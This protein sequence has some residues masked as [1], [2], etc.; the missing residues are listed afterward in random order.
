MP[1][2]RTK[3]TQLIL[4]KLGSQEMGGQ[5]SGFRGQRKLTVQESISIR[6]TDFYRRRRSRASGTLTRTHFD[7]DQ[8]HVRYV[9]DS[10]GP[11]TISLAYRCGDQDIGMLIRLQSTETR[12]EGNRWWFTCPLSV[13][14]S[15]CGRRVHTL[16]LP[17]GARYFGCRQC[18]RLSYSSSQKAHEFERF[19]LGMDKFLA[20]AGIYAARLA[21]D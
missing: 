13:D 17:P 7:R 21:A 5:G 16:H 1:L 2:D 12:F 18:H 20:R 3:Q 9:V 10:R 11:W 8:F 6:V 4:A 15:P 19:E 14:G